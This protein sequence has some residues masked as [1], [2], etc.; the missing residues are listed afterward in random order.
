MYK[1]TPHKTS[2][3][4]VPIAIRRAGEIKLFSRAYLMAKIM[5]NSKINPPIQENNSTKEIGFLS[6]LTGRF[7]E[8]VSERDKSERVSSFSATKFVAGTAAGSGSGD[9]KGSEAG[10][11]DSAI[12]TAGFSSAVLVDVA[13]VSS[14]VCTGTCV[15]VVATSVACCS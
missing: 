10:D 3:V 11:T 14:E 2:P 12:T 15:G 9:G 8:D 6:S 13:S 7:S 1:P 4:I 5:P